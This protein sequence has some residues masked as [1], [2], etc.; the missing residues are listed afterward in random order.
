MREVKF[1]A[2]DTVANMWFDAEWWAIRPNGKQLDWWG[3]D[4]TYSRNIAPNDI[5]LVQYTGLID[6]NGA[7]IHEGDIIAYDERDNVAK[8]EYIAAGFYLNFKQNIRQL[9]PDIRIE[10]IGNIYES[11]ELLNG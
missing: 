3:G 10:V 1:K 7:E 9:I 2:W 5:I 4:E 8:V 6:R 11:P